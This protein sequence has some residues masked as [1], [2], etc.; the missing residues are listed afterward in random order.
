PFRARLLR[1]VRRCGV[2]ELPA[3]SSGFIASG[4]AGNEIGARVASAGVG[5]PGLMSPRCG[6]ASLLSKAERVPEMLRIG[7]A[8]VAL[9]GRLGPAPWRLDSGWSGT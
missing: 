1:D 3:A 9:F 7:A 5:P 2:G 4:R 6:M 8:A